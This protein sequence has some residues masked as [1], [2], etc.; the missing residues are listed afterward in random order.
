MKK[1]FTGGIAGGIAYFLLG[2]LVWG[3]L[4]MSFMME[5]SN[6]TASVIFRS[7]TEMVWWAMI[8]GNIAMGFLVS[9]IMLRA[10][11]SS[12]VPGAVTG[13]VVGFLFS[14]GINCIM[15]AQMKI[16]GTT[17]MAADIIASA[18]VAAIVSAIVVVVQGMGNK[19]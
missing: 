1:L 4:L 2:W 15:Y 12:A 5:H 17:A 19:S 6:P 13:A 16:Y 9:Y 8:A 14:L 11:I 3:K 10:G 7:E 18:V